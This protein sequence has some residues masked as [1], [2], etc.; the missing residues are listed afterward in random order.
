MGK[1]QNP[2]EYDIHISGSEV[3]D[4]FKKTV[5]FLIA[6]TLISSYIPPLQTLASKGEIYFEY[7]F[8]DYEGQNI[9]DGGNGSLGSWK[10]IAEACSG[11]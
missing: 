8:N 9:F 3:T 4:L 2:K 7:N 1:L 5:L 6:V 11:I 10:L